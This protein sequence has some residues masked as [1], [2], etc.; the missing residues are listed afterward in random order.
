MRFKLWMIVAMFSLPVVLWAQALPDFVRNRDETIRNLQS[1]I[2][3][4]TSNPP[5]NETQAVQLIKS[6]LDKEGVPSE[7]FAL[8]QN[9]ANL[10]ARIKGNGRKRPILLMGHT[11]V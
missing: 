10:V 1:L 4:D 11:D 2:R 6:I 3:L 9:R 5:G 8:D 7:V